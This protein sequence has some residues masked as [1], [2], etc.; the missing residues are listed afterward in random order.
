[1]GPARDCSNRDTSV[2]PGSGPST[3]EVTPQLPAL[4]L[5]ISTVVTTLLELF[6]LEEEEEEG[7][8]LPSLR[9]QTPLYRQGPG[10]RLGGRLPGYRL[11][12]GHGLG[13]IRWSPDSLS[14]G[15]HFIKWLSP[16]DCH[17]GGI[18]S[19]FC[20]GSFREEGSCLLVGGVW[21]WLA[22]CPSF[23]SV[24]LVG[25]GPLSAKWLLEESC[26]LRRL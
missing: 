14:D 12:C 3:P 1:M 19:P 8:D 7:S 20:L 22:S 23:T 21:T 6:G 13:V 25:A 2:Y 17:L 18:S 9:V 4:F 10:Y 24:D 11:L 15:S 5:I 16:L 26:R